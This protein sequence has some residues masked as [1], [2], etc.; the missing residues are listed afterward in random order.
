MLSH[1]RSHWLLWVAG[2]IAVGG[3]ITMVWSLREP[4]VTAVQFD[5]ATVNHDEAG[6]ARVLVR[7]RGLHAGLQALLVPD[8]LGAEAKLWRPV[9]DNTMYQLATDGRLAVASTAEHRLITLDVTAGKTIE[10]LGGVQLL[11]RRTSASDFSI[12][13]MALV[14]SK[15]L[16]G[17][18]NV[19]LIMIDVANPTAPREVD[20]IENLGTFSD[21]GS[22]G[23]EAYVVSR[24]SGL[25]AVTVEGERLRS[26][27]VPGSQGA[28][29]LAVEGGRLVTTSLKG[30]L[31]L[32][33]LDPQGGIQ[34]VGKLQLPQDIR[35]LTICRETLYL[36][37]AN[38][39]LLGFSLAHWPRLVPSGQLNLQGR[40]MRLEAAPEENRLFCTLVS[41]GIAVVDI[42]RADAPQQ[43]GLIPMHK[44]ATTLQVKN[45]RLFWA[46]IAG[47]QIAP[48]AEL[49]NLPPAPET[50][51]PFEQHQGKVQLLPWRNKVF[52]YNESGL[53]Q[54]PDHGGDSSPSGQEFRTEEPFLV[55]PTP[56]GLR[57]HGIR[58]GLPETAAAAEVPIYDPDS[59][60][61]T[62]ANLIRSATWH[63]GRL[64]VLTTT[65]LQIFDGNSA[66]ATALVG[67]HRFARATGAMAWVG[68]GLV[69]VTSHNMEFSGFEVIDVS[70]PA[71]PRVVARYAIPKHQWVV[72]DI[73]DILID[74]TRLFMSRSRLGVEVFD[75][76][77]PVAPKLM[78]RI[79][80]PGYAG[81]LSLDK[82]LLVVS[83]QD[84][85]V[86]MIDV[87]GKFGLP[88]GSYRLPTI[89]A[90]V[91]NY[92]DRI[93]IT[94]SGGGVMHFPAPRRLVPEMVAADGEMELFIPAGMPPGRYSLILY[95]GENNAEFPVILQ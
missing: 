14:G 26:R 41:K 49:E 88:V 67:E 57:L 54:L 77:D 44:L 16:V 74:G 3:L 34:P 66:G 93:F 71:T 5:T 84:E 70:N 48:L 62:P 92:N 28:W 37:S 56:V 9:L 68:S 33:E 59:D 20:R 86:F 17:R 60:K 6:K 11:P 21:I 38:G 47:L 40:P 58:K 94:T 7:G 15:A 35:D 79:D 90:E 75:L 25:L 29:R 8:Q 23:G 45:G 12:N 81:K 27:Q 39:Q 64:F 53:F 72:G 19:G 22:A 32:Y 30:L 51:H 10:I 80:T 50:L 13:C 4:S 18:S 46:G 78:Q 65:T 1:R 2:L 83:D 42:S 82:G 95:D 52:V 43:A 63:A 85:G 24:T 55:L 76:S 69:M 91:L 87:T 36:C 73:D 31:T 61:V 89:A